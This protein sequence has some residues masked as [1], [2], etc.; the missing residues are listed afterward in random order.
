VGIVGV[1]YYWLTLGCFICIRL[2]ARR[3]T[4]YYLLQFYDLQNFV[5][6]VMKVSKEL[7]CDRNQDHSFKIS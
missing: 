5:P 1:Q 2:R 4:M 3:L 6:A 7:Q